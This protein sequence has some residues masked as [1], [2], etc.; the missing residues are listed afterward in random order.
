M[1]VLGHISDKD[2]FVSVFIFD[3]FGGNRW[4]AI[5]CYFMGR[6]NRNGK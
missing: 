2:E 3:L 5:V 6:M 1:N 4:Y